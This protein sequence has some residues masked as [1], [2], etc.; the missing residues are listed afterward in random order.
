MDLD[1]F[2]L[3]VKYYKSPS[4]TYSIVISTHFRAFTLNEAT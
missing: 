3:M 2:F 4:S 1:S